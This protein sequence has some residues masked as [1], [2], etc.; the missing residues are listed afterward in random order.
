M[1]ENE[2]KDV[3]KVA[4]RT[5]SEV[6]EGKHKPAKITR[7]NKPRPKGPIN[8]KSVKVDERIME[9][10][11]ELTKGDMSRIQIVSETEVII[12]NSAQHKKRRTRG[13]GR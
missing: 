10:V 4:P 3:A 12:Y 13:H 5:V 9:T 8:P 11:R 6:S 7:K 1:S 2:F